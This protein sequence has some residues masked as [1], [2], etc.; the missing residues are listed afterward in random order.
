MWQRLASALRLHLALSPIFA[1]I[2]GLSEVRIM[3]LRLAGGIFVICT[4]FVS[5]RFVFFLH[6]GSVYKL[7]NKSSADGSDDASPGRP[8][9]R[10]RERS[11]ETECPIIR[12][13]ASVGLR[14]ANG[15]TRIQPGPRVTISRGSARRILLKNGY[16]LVGLRNAAV[17]VAWAL[18]LIRQWA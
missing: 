16:V 8:G 12:L 15:Q 10:R 9:G 2:T 13:R 6:R 18:G 17:N 14:R 1:D 4:E 7:P 11:C 3:L 5:R